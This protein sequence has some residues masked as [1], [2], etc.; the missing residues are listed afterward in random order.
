MSDVI[1]GYGDRRKESCSHSSVNQNTPSGPV[2]RRLST[3][4]FYL[5][6]FILFFLY[7][8]NLIPVS[9]GN[10][11]DLANT[12]WTFQ[13]LDTMSDTNG[14][15]DSGYHNYSYQKNTWSFTD[16]LFIR[17]S[18]SSLSTTCE[19]CADPGYGLDTIWSGDSIVLIIHRVIPR[20]PTEYTRDQ[21]DTMFYSI[22]NDTFIVQY[23]T[24]SMTDDTLRYRLSQAGDTL[25]IIYGSV[26]MPYTRENGTL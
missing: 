21:T 13:A 23:H 7:C 11:P 4:N 2:K 10:V 15:I 26:E 3:V 20:C 1:T 19:P 14:C 12:T 8:S 25:L 18:Y 22:H 24:V 17:R 6:S 5:V 16:S 9:K